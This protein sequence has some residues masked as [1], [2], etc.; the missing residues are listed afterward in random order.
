MLWGRQDAMGSTGCYGVQRVLW[1]PEGAM[2][3]DRVL[4]GR[5]DAMGSRGRYWRS[6]TEKVGR[7]FSFCDSTL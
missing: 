2:G 7:T 4:W 3:V 6:T 1:G 5:Q